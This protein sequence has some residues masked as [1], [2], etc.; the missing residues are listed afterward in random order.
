MLR[1]FFLSDINKM[2]LIF[3]L[4]SAACAF[5]LTALFVYMAWTL[6]PDDGVLP[7]ISITKSILSE[8]FLSDDKQKQKLLAY[9]SIAFSAIS[10]L[11]A[12]FVTN[13]F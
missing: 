2:E 5:V 12:L 13:F 10:F 3:P 6:T 9:L 4:K 1:S 7:G 11:S 8:N